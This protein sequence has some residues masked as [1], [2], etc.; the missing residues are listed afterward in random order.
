MRCGV[1][2]LVARL[3]P[4]EVG[5]QA[6]A[7]PV[8]SDGGMVRVAFADPTDPAALATVRPHVPCI[9]VAVAELSDIRT[10]LQAAFSVSR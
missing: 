5:M 1:D 6:A 3:V 7:I 10:A 2:P 8:R 4:Y 9:E